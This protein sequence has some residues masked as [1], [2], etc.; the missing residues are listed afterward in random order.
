MVTTYS[1]INTETVTRPA[2]MGRSEVET[3]IGVVTLNRPEVLN[4]LNLP[5]VRELD[6]AITDYEADD[7]VGAGHHHRRGRAG[8]L[9]RC[10]HPREPGVVCRRAGSRPAGTRG[11]HW[12]LHTSSK[13]IIGAVNGLCYGGGTVLATSLD[14]LVGCEK[15]QLPFPGGELRPDER[16]LEPAAAGGHHRAKELLLSGREVFADEAYH[17][18]LI[19][20][21][22]P[23]EELM[24]RTLD[25]AAGIARNRVA[26][27]ANIKQ[28][29]LEHSGLP[30]AEQYR[31]EIE[32]RTG[33]FKGL[34]VEEGFSDFLARKGAKPRSA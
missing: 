21:L 1:C 3:H 7:S 31:N 14:F 11:I 12:H 27:L 13:P 24:E 2:M 25:I 29:L 26:G 16:H 22:V 30:I 20:H 19:N 5:L 32:G 9:R 15:N 4:A 33:R 10:R 23:A 6:E 17:I 34:S 28:L 18:G 8:F